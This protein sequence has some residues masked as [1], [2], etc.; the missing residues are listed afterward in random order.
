MSDSALS[1]FCVT[2]EEVDFTVEEH[3]QEVTRH[4]QGESGEGRKIGSLDSRS[5]NALRQESLLL[6]CRT[7]Q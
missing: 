4:W 3:R 7:T 1:Q 2:A 6:L 5:Q